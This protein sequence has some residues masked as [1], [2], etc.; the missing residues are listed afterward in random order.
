MS[1]QRDFKG[2][3]IP[4]EI[5]L[6]EDLSWT[7]KILLIEIDSL[8]NDEEK[9]CFASNQYFADFLKIKPMSVSNMIAKLKEKGF[10]KQIHFDG[11]N[12]GLRLSFKLTEPPQ[13]C[14]HRLHKKM[15]QTPQ[16]NGS[17]P[18]QKCGHNNTSKESLI[19]QVEEEARN[20]P[21]TPTANAEENAEQRTDFTLPTS[22]DFKAHARHVPRRMTADEA[23]AYLEQ[24]NFTEPE[25]SATLKIYREFYPTVFLSPYQIGL[26]E[27][28]TLS[29]E[30]FRAVLRYWKGKGNSATNID[31]LTDCYRNRLKEKNNQTPGG[32]M[33]MGAMQTGFLSDAIKR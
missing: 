30:V 20:A 14:G 16:K 7:E 31:G 3:W 21:P 28:E 4:K 29:E 15:V 33:P 13:K 10:V 17:E 2:V 11:R 6:A 22:S 25:E 18:P 19:I 12:R 24:N 8:D 5:Y 32:F 27:K 26:L 23:A 9:G 1:K